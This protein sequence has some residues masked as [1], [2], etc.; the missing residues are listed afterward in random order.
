MPSLVGL[1][2]IKM[3]IFH[4]VRDVSKFKLILRIRMDM[5]PNVTFGFNSNEPKN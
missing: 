1:N 2:S 5:I 4:V 3:N